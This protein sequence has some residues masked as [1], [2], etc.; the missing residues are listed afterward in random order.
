MKWSNSRRY[1][2]YAPA[3]VV[4]SRPHATN[5]GPTPTGQSS[6]YP[7]DGIQDLTQ[8]WSQPAARAVP[9]QRRVDGLPSEPTGVRNLART[10]C[11]PPARAATVGA[12]P[13]DDLV[14]REDGSPDR[15]LVSVLSEDSP[16]MSLPGVSHP[17]AQGDVNLAK[18]E[19]IKSS[20]IVHQDLPTDRRIG[21]PDG[22]LVQQPAVVDL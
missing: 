1:E 10:W 14:G 9:T 3:A 22:K 7:P 11:P 18:L 12:S 19:L 4:L 15:P 13:A 5:S 21:R 8:R 6:A 2:V 17:L 20:R 16:A